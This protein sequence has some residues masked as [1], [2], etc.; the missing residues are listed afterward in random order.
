MPTNNEIEEAKTY[1][2]KRIEAENS[3]GYNLD[4]YMEI[5]ASRMVDIGYKY[6]IP[7]SKFRFSSNRKMEE[8]INEVIDW[9]K[10]EIEDSVYEL[11]ASGGTGD[12]HEIILFIS[13]EN[14]GRTFL[15]RNDMYCR[16]FKY[17]VE[18]AIAA[19]LLLGT[20]KEK[21]KKSINTYLK[22]PY[23]NPYFKEAVK[24]KSSSIRLKNNGVSYG[25][26]HTNSAFTALDTLTRHA[27]SQGWMKHWLS[28]HEGATGFYSYRGSSYPC[29]TCDINAGWHPISEYTGGWHLRCKCFFVFT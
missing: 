27:V 16:R 23:E 17:E 12:A 22:S 2:R 10:S 15:Q 19:G 1:I 5:A 3:M 13:A 24:I 4:R 29:S 9:L 26:G 7:P 28:V 11:A 8:E 20:A 25:Q 18:A 6:N 21:I 14:Q